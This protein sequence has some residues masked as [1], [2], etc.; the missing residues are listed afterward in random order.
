MV[1]LYPHHP[2]GMHTVLGT[3]EDLKNP[4]ITN[5]KNYYKTYYVPNN[6]AICLVGDFDPR[7]DD[8]DDRQVLRRTETQ[9]RTA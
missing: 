3:Q 7:P 2:Y 4:S 8:R 9:S 6:M 1:A 5:I